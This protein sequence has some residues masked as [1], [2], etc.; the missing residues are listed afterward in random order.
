VTT[1]YVIGSGPSLSGFDFSTLP[2]GYRIG[3][4]KSAWLADC[5][6]MVSIDKRFWRGH[7]DQISSFNGDKY[8]TQETLQDQPDYGAKVMQHDRGDGFSTDQNTLR[9]SNSGFAALNLAYLL[10][11]R[12]IALLG[13]DFRWS[14]GSSHFHDGYAWQ[15]KQADKHLA[16]WCRAFDTIDQSDVSIVNFVG[17]SGSRINAFRVRPL[18]DLV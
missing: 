15:N 7:P 17:P 1:C 8:I 18:S 11:Y 6:A 9:G 3:A 13:F 12:E 10:G 2:S 14:E 5:D 16:T 4:N